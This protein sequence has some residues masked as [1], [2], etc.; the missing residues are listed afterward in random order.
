MTANALIHQNDELLEQAKE[1]YNKID[2]EKLS[3]KTEDKW[4]FLEQI[5]A[6]IWSVRSIVVLN[7][8]TE[9][10]NFFPLKVMIGKWLK[11]HW[12]LIFCILFPKTSNLNYQNFTTVKQ[13]WNAH[14]SRLS[15]PSIM[16]L[17]YEPQNLKYIFQNLSIEV[18]KQF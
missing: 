14:C 8:L 13:S 10:Y 4:Q 9:L 17:I 5:F 7:I 16:C 11:S 12:N 1:S 18:L 15:T 3:E 6:G 2:Q